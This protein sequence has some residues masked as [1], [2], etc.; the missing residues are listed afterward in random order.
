MDTIKKECYLCGEDFDGLC[1]GN[2]Y[3]DLCSEVLEVGNKDILASIIAEIIQ[4]K[5][6]EC[7]N[8]GW[9]WLGNLKSNF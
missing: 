6:N 4:L 1:D 9:N 3:C 2:R 5:E 8:S 7:E